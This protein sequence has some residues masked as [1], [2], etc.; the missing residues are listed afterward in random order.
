M[1]RASSLTAGYLAGCCR[2]RD[3]YTAVRRRLPVLAVIS[4]LALGATAHA[5][6]PVKL[7]FSSSLTNPKSISST[8]NVTIGG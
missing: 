1:M 3:G 5:A 8:F 4:V 7:A 6:T 2:V